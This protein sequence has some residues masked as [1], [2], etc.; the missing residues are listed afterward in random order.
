MELSNIKDAKYQVGQE[1]VNEETR[2]LI[3]LDSSPGQMSTLDDLLAAHK[4]IGWVQLPMAGI[5]A[6]ASLA[7]KY[8]DKVWT[9][10]KV[11][12]PIDESETDST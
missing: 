7:E 9:S 1:S 5:N 11:R 3:W 12:R 10:A 8:S 4:N 6:Y 2:G